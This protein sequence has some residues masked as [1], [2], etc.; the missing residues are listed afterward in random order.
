MSAV[1]ILTCVCPLI[2]TQNSMDLF[3]AVPSSARPSFWGEWRVARIL[4]HATDRTA[5]AKYFCKFTAGCVRYLWPKVHLLIPLI[6]KLICL[7]HLCMY[8]LT[9]YTHLHT[10]CI[11]FSLPQAKKRF[12]L[13]ACPNHNLWIWNF[14]LFYSLSYHINAFTIIFLIALTL[15][16]LTLTGIFDSI[17][18]S[19]EWVRK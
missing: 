6:W 5:T 2:Y 8:K 15:L 9:G 12:K 19:I 13:F 1:K 10:E 16:S 14:L 4:H 11:T 3:R 17:P 7:F 18:H